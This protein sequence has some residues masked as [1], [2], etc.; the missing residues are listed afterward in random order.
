ME[1]GPR[2][3]PRSQ[4]AIEKSSEEIFLNRRRA[5]SDLRENDACYQHNVGG[6]RKKRYRFQLDDGWCDDQLRRSLMSEMA[7]GAMRIIDW[8]LMM[9][10][11]DDAGG[12]DHQRNQRE[13]NPEDANRFACRHFNKS[14][15]N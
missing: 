13:R 4:C 15:S 9:P 12:K 11:A 8:A 2:Y 14:A 3:P 1:M 6:R 5:R 7:I 10:V